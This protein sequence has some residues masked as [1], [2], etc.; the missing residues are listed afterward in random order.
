MENRPAN[1]GI[2][3]FEGF[4]LDS[5]EQ[6]LRRGAEKITLTPKAV[7]LL[8]ILVKRHGQIVTREE[9]LNDLWR[10]T[11]VDESNLTVTVS[12]LRRAFG[13]NANDRRFI[14]TVPKRGYRFNAEVRTPDELIVER[15]TR[16]FIKIKETETKTDS[17]TAVAALKRGMRRYSFAMAATAAAVL[18]VLLGGSYAWRGG[19]EAAGFFATNA[20]TARAVAV[21]PFTFP[22][23]QIGAVTTANELTAAIVEKLAATAQIV[24]PDSMQAEGATSDNFL[25]VG[26]KLRTD[27]VLV[28]TVFDHPTDVYLRVHLVSTGDGKVLWANTYRVSPNDA[29]GLPADIAQNVVDNLPKLAAPE[30][31][32]EQSMRYTENE[33]AD[34]LY[35]QGRFIWRNR[36]DVFGDEAASKKYFEAALRLDPNYALPMIGLADWQKTNTYD[37]EDRKNAEENLRRALELAPDSAD[38]RAALGFM[39][40]IHDWNWQAAELEFQTALQIDPNSVNALQWYALLLALQTRHKDAT[41]KISIARDLVP[42]QANIKVDQAEIMFLQRK[43]GEAIWALR[44]TQTEIPSTSGEILADIYFLN[45]NYAEAADVYSARLGASAE[46]EKLRR[47]LPESDAIRTTSVFMVKY[48]DREKKYDMW[49][50]YWKAEWLAVA[51]EK[52]EALD[53]LEQAATE[54][55]FFIVWIKANPFF[56]NLRNEPRYQNL[57]KRIGLAGAAASRERS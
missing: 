7:E 6:E 18:M 30:T 2:Y 54:H 27:A 48:Y 4:R 46:L 25:V 50:S 20:Q 26:K 37:S 29:L 14:E 12:V 43:Y 39:R 38:A 8:S 28:G 21:L 51:G 31:Y 19:N 52:E 1:E 49:S 17:R 16:T 45:G 41:E 34:T 3:E 5:N 13:I 57:I 47:P 36:G 15:Q 44:Q 40:M 35:Q 53:L 56:E 9:I 23:K 11:F 42:Y 24:S 33:E 10:D 32:R 22:N 55:H